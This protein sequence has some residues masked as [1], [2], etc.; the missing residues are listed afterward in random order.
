MSKA[1]KKFFAGFIV[2]FLIGTGVLSGLA[3]ISGCATLRDNPDATELVVSQ[4]VT[5]YIDEAAPSARATRAQRIHDVVTEVEKFASGE[6]VTI[7]QFAALALSAI[8]NDLSVPDRALATSV[9]NLL[10]RALS[11]RI[12][13]GLL[14]PEDL[15]TVKQVLAS[16]RFYASLYLR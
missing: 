1:I 4:V 12:G 3:S 11:Q 13:D 7:A 6:S 8:P 16:V 15:V 5:R 10:S 2:Y 14:K 9:V